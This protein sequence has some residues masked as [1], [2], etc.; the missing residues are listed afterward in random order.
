MN[1]NKTVENMERNIDYINNIYGE[2]ARLGGKYQ[3]NNCL[4][5][6]IN[7]C[8]FEGNKEIIQEFEYRN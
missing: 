6:N 4:Q 1:N 3:Y 5:I 8:N 7:N 2:R